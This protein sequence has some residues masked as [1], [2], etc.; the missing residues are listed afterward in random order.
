M[1]FY[2]SKIIPA[3]LDLVK[4]Q[5]YLAQVNVKIRMEQ[6]ESRQMW[7]TVGLCALASLATV[8]AVIFMIKRSQ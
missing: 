6:I 7:R 8:G 4:D 2:L 5:S 1:P 3:Y